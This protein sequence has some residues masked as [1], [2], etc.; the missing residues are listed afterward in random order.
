M[1]GDIAYLEADMFG[2]TN[3]PCEAAAMK[4]WE[5]VSYCRAEPALLYRL[6]DDPAWAGFYAWS[7]NF[8]QIVAQQDRAKLDVELPDDLCR[9]VLAASRK[10]YTLSRGYLRA[11]PSSQPGQQ[12]SAIEAYERCG[13]GFLEEVN[14]AG[15]KEVPPEPEP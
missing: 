11:A 7:Q 5:L 3:H 15:S 9:H 12:F 1:A 4:F 2:R 14:E 10:R 8:D 13:G 6:A